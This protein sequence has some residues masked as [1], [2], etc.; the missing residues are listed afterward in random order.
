MSLRNW[1]SGRVF[2]FVHGNNLVY[3]TCW[4]DPR[5]DRVALELS[6]QDRLL[7][8]TSAGCNALD[9]A[10]AGAGQVHAVDM[11]PRQNA[12]LE[13]KLA[14]ATQLQQE[15]FF[16]LF[17][18]GYLPKVAQ[19]YSQ[20]LRQQLSPWSAQYWDR[21]IKLFDNPKR[22]F[23]FRGTSGRF[24]RG[25]NVYID[26]VTGVRKELTELL[27]SKTLA[28]QQQLFRKVRDKIW[29][30]LLRFA[31]ARDTTLSML[32][33]PQPQRQQ[34]DRQYPGGIVKFVEDSLDAVFGEIPIQDNYFWRVYITG[35]YTPACCPEYLK[36]DNFAAL[37]RLVAEKRIAVHT[38]SVQSFLEQT[39][40]AFTRFVLLDHM[41]WLSDRFFPLLESEWQAIVNRAAPGARLLWRSGGLQT[42]F[43]DQVRVMLD[44]QLRPL[45][46]LLHYNR[47]LAEQLHTSDRVHT[48]GSFYIAQLAV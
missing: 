5:L 39:D 37:Q 30:G 20:K 42:D 28:D 44:G 27:E 17:G 25:I 14:G 12:L 21:W 29:T 10:L 47:E 11:N 6:D 45:P 41:D 13:L 33:V 40:Q 8:I 18:E 16:K 3:N 43:L 32:G 2:H 26:R 7:V 31:M 15:D 46:E 1:I 23:Y 48:Y 38:A 24:A 19:V 4:E 22:S 35:R 36:P 34:I 9:Y